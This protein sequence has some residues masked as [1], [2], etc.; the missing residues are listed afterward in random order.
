MG[1]RQGFQIELLDHHFLGDRP[2]I[3]FSQ[4]LFGGGAHLNLLTLRTH[5]IA[6]V[7]AEMKRVG[8]TPLAIMPVPALGFVLYFYAFTEDRPPNDDLYAV[9]NRPWLYQRPYTVLEVV[10]R[11]Q[12]FPMEKAVS[13]E[14]GY[15]GARVSGLPTRSYKFDPLMLSG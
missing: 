13:H 7:E 6:P 4:D 1:P 9:G 3:S 11:E 12:P 2:T 10:H 14:A 15:A 8:M 5:D